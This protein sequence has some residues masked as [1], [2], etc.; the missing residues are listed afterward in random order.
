MTQEAVATETADVSQDVTD[1]QVDKFFET[2]EI[3]GADD[4]LQEEATEE[5]EQEEIKEELKEA[6]KEVEDT[7]KVPLAALHE[8]RQRRKE[9]Q[10]QALEDRERIRKMEERFA[11][12]V[13]KMQPQAPSYEEDPIEHV[14]S[15]QEK[16]TQQLA[17]QK[18]SLDQQKQ[19]QAIEA[20]KQE[21]ISRYQQYATIFAK[22]TPD[23]NEAYNHLL[24]VRAQ[25]LKALGCPDNQIGDILAQEEIGI[26]LKSFDD[27]VNPAQRIYELAKLR[28]Y[29]KEAKTQ[30]KLDQVSKGQQANRSLSGVKGQGKDELS[31]EALADMSDAE[32]D[33]TWDKF[34][35]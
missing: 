14:R 4:G 21:V 28:G 15:N 23:F 6:T 29:R 10:A 11:Q 9:L 22:E 16:L 33:Q 3:E 26:A 19:A 1:E 12:L 7:P 35:K 34:F 8:E 18:Q 13:E 5:V 17:E 25:E 30:E 31:L 24:S 20:Q 2:G 27:E 32:F